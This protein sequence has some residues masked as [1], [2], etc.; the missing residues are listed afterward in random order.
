MV[1]HDHFDEKTDY[2]ITLTGK[3][4]KL[5]SDAVPFVRLNQAIADIAPSPRS[6]RAQ[7]NA[8][9]KQIEIEK[10]VVQQCAVDDVNPPDVQCEVG[11]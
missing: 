2:K 7:S 10:T 11:T 6:K 9:K 8:L 5:K 3:N 4:K 1:C